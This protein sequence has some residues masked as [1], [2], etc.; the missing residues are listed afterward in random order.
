MGRHTV[1]ALTAATALALV[2]LAPSWLDRSADADGQPSTELVVRCAP[3]RV[4]SIVD[5]VTRQGGTVHDRA[6]LEPLRARA[7]GAAPGLPAIRSI[8]PVWDGL[9]ET[10]SV[11]NASAGRHPVSLSHVDIQDRRMQLTVETQDR[12]LIDA[13]QRALLKHPVV[14]ARVAGANRPVERAT[15]RKDRSGSWRADLTVHFGRPAEAKPPTEDAERTIRLDDLKTASKRAGVELIYASNEHLEAHR[16]TGLATIWRAVTYAR[17]ESDGLQSLLRELES[18]R[19][20]SVAVLRVS[21]DPEGAAAFEKVN[22]RVA[23]RI[24]WRD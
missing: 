18:I 20:V 2:V 7:R 11:V 13:L 12:S 5:F 16:R 14:A 21:V 4:Q 22:V 6:T 1:L 9:H 3:D 15:A 8:I 23:R 19:G 17:V 24:H 10:L